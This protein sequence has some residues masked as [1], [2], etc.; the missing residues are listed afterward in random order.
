MGTSV[1]SEGM[2]PVNNNMMAT[3]YGVR[4]ANQHIDPYLMH[5]LQSDQT[6][7]PLTD[8]GGTFSIDGTFFPDFIP[9]SLIPSLARP[10]DTDPPLNVAQDYVHYGAFDHNLQF[11]FN[12]S[13]SDFGLIDIFNSRGTLQDT[14]LHLETAESNDDFDADSGIAIGA[15]AF[16][17]SSLSAWKPAQEDHA[18]ADQ[19]NLS[20]PK[21]I[22]SP[23]SG[24]T[25]DRRILSE[26]LSAS[27]RDLI[28]GI[29][30]ETSKQANMM[31]IMKSFPSAELLDSLIQSF[32]ERQRAQL[33]S[34][35]HGP[36]FQTN[37]EDPEMLA[38]LAASG[39]VRSTIP[40][41]RKLGYALM[42]IVRLHFPMK[43]GTSVPGNGVVS[44]MLRG[45]V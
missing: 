32:F 42:E 1:A 20:V 12:L 3:A 40:T 36:T 26:R 18:L 7:S 43:V 13:D 15:E 19:E 2:S 38:A 39:A 37:Q 34:W 28:F 11:D 23:E 22:D 33:D 21:S 30:L 45:I 44:N 9:D 29:V 6:V 5:K 16:R 35:V 41:I 14:D 27:N 17:R 25:S 10:S 24:A 4:P 8:E 31:R